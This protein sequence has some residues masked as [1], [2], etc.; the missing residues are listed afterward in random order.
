MAVDPTGLRT[1]LESPKLHCLKSI[2]ISYSDWSLDP[3]RPYGSLFVGLSSAT[4]ESVMFTMMNIVGDNT[5]QQLCN[6]DAF[7]RMRSLA[8]CDCP[9]INDSLLWHRRN[10]L[11]RLE[12]LFIKDCVYVTQVVQIHGFSFIAN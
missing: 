1:L 6:Q 5:I 10:E 4:L 2:H 11:C 3:V 8:F 7:P 9:L 12:G